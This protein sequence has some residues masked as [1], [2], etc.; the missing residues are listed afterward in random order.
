MSWHFLPLNLGN[1]CP[2][3]WQLPSSSED[4]R[5]KRITN[6][7]GGKH[8][9][10]IEDLNKA[11]NQNPNSAKAYSFRGFAYA[12]K[13]LYDKAITDYNKALE[14]NPRDADAY[15]NWGLAWSGKSDY[16]HACSDFQKACKLGDCNRLNWAKKKGYC[17]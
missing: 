4:V 9:L 16:D 13:R 7:A 10:T 6:V 1:L 8:Q 14:I 12:K 11:I 2:D 5:Q 17:Q 15:Y 3:I